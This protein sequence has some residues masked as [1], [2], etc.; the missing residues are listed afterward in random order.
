MNNLWNQ[1]RIYVGITM[2]YGFARGSV[3]TFGSEKTYFNYKTCCEEKKPML[4]T[5]RAQSVLHCS[6]VAPIMWPGML[7]EDA[8]YLE[9]RLRGK[10]PET[11]GRRS[12][13]DRS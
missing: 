2:L 7:G 3:S 9:M 4:L 5:E 11:Y 6:F 12:Y 10:D 8:V 1:G 13:G